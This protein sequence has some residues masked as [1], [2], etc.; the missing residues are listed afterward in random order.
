MAGWALNINVIIKKKK[1]KNVCGIFESPRGEF[2]QDHG[3]GKCGRVHCGSSV[4]N[5]QDLHI[6][7]CT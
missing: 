5:N 2:V 3:N 4:Y 6:I 1:K 7:F